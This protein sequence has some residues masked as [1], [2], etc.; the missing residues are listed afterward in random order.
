ML[1]RIAM[2]L[3]EAVTSGLE[4][5]VHA[6]VAANIAAIDAVCEFAEGVGTEMDL[7]IDFSMMGTYSTTRTPRLPMTKLERESVRWRYVS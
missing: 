7:P 5:I 4:T 2:L 6:A 3:A 1:E